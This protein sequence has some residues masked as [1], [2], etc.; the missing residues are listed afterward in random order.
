MNPP[1]SSEGVVRSEFYTEFIGKH[2]NKSTCSFAKVP[3]MFTVSRWGTAV[4]VLLACMGLAACGGSSGHKKAPQSGVTSTSTAPGTSNTT[5][6]AALRNPAAAK[7]VVMRIAGKPITQAEVE[8]VMAIGQVKKEVPDPPSYTACVAH[9]QTSEAKTGQGSAKPTVAQLKSQCAHTYEVLKSQALHTLIASTWVIR[10]ASDLGLNV[11]DAEV[12]QRYEQEKNQAYKSEA[13]L[14]QYLKTSGQTVSDLVSGVRLE[15]D[16]EA[17]RKY[18]KRKVGPVTQ[19]RIASYYNTHKQ[20]YVVPE[21]RDIEAIRTWTK[22]AI[23]K[24]KQEVKSGTNFGDVAKRV[25]IDRPSNEHGGVTL[26]VVR[27][28][29]EK[30]LDEAIFAAKPHTLVGPLHLRQRYY[31]FEVTKI[32][33]ARQKPFQEIETS[34]SQQLPTELEQQA[35][36]RFIK[37]WREK[38]RVK[39]DCSVGW[40]VQKCRQYRASTATI[41]PEVEVPYELD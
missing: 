40:I 36:V 5:T 3:A 26:G 32:T 20:L 24:A 14:Q 34:I 12:H 13:A 35:L 38:W 4:A 16:S 2:S 28:Q 27:G 6:D 21:Q 8:H 19:A 25:S 7:T 9:L 37:T 17:I 10:E 41:H 39:T 22:T 15:L 1:P 23:T 18:V 11:S 31:I 30:G 29:E 33:P